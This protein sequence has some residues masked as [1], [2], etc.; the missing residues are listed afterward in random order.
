MYTNHIIFRNAHQMHVHVQDALVILLVSYPC[1]TLMVTIKG[2]CSVGKAPSARSLRLN[3][4]VADT[5]LHPL[6]VEAHSINSAMMATNTC[7]CAL[8]SLFQEASEHSS[9]D[10]ETCQAICMTVSQLLYVSARQRSTQQQRQGS[11]LELNK[12]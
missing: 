10:D 11:G 6:M 9:Y 5:T 8:H 2:R 1:G 12:R 7:H 4:T 3:I